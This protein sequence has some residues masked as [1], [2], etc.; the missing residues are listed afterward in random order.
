MTL[1]MLI[2]DEP[3]MHC[4][5]TASSTGAVLRALDEQQVVE[6]P[7]GIHYMVDGVRCADDDLFV[8]TA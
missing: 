7:F 1:T 8:K 5:D 3:D 4:V 6:L 2:N